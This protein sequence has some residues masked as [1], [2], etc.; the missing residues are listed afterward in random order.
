MAKVKF[1]KTYKDLELDRIVKADEEVEM[2]LKRADELV[3]T[4]SKKAS[5]FNYER[6]DKPKTDKEDKE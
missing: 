5:D 6:L 1:N 2:T 4:I 3:E